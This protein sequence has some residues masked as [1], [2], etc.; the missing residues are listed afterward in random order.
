MVN[1]SEE[2]LIVSDFLRGLETE[3]N[4]RFKIGGIRRIMLHGQIAHFIDE[5]GKSCMAKQLFIIDVNH[6]AD[7]RSPFLRIF[8][9]QLLQRHRHHIHIEKELID[10]ARHFVDILALSQ[11]L[12]IAQSC[13]GSSRHGGEHFYMFE[14]CS[15][16]RLHMM[17]HGKCA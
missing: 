7:G 16:F 5:I 13:E 4:A 3:G 12:H 9:I 11:R 15:C 17:K 6:R 8:I 1:I 2:A 10:A 14:E